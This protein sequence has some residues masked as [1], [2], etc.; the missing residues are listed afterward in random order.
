MRDTSYN[1]LPLQPLLAFWAAEVRLID[2]ST[3]V[4]I[5]ETLNAYG[6]SLI[7]SGNLAQL[8]MLIGPILAQTPE[9]QAIFKRIF[10]EQYLPLVT[11]HVEGWEAR[12]TTSQPVSSVEERATNQIKKLR[13]LVY[14]LLILGA[15]GLNVG[16]FKN[17]MP[18][19][20][21]VEEP[22]VEGLRDAPEVER[23]ALEVIETE[24]KLPYELQQR[25]LPDFHMADHAPTFSVRAEKSYEG[26]DTRKPLIFT[27]NPSSQS[28]AYTYRWSMDGEILGEEKIARYQFFLP[29]LYTVDLDRVGKEGINGNTTSHSKGRGIIFVPKVNHDKQEY[30]TFHTEVNEGLQDEMKV[31]VLFL[32]LLIVFFAEGG[33]RLFKRRAK[34]LAFKME[35]EKLGDVA[36]ALPFEH[37]EKIFTSDEDLEKLARQLHRR[38]T[39]NSKQL[40]IPRSIDETIKMAG[41]PHLV[42][43]TRTRQAEYVFLLDDDPQFDFAQRSMYGLIEYLQDQDLALQQYFFERDPSVAFHPTQIEGLDW[44]RITM[45]HPHSHLI[46]F[47]DGHQWFDAQT[48]KLNPIV[49]KHFDLWVEKT[50]LTPIPQAHWGKQEQ[51][52]SLYFTLLPLERVHEL[53]EYQGEVSTEVTSGNVAE[54]IPQTQSEIEARLGKDLTQWLAASMI[55]PQPNWEILLKVGRTIEREMQ[56]QTVGLEESSYFALELDKEELVTWKNLQLLSQ[57]PW[58]K[59]G[60]AFPEG[61]RREMLGHLDEDLAHQVR[62]AILDVV[63]AA[64]VEEGSLAH[65]EQRRQRAIHE[66]M[67]Y[68]EDKE[69]QEKLRYLMMKDQMDTFNW[70]SEQTSIDVMTRLGRYIQHPA[71]RALSMLA[72]I[73]ILGILGGGVIGRYQAHQREHMVQRHFVDFTGQSLPKETMLTHSPMNLDEW[74]PKE[75]IAHIPVMI[76]RGDYAEAVSLLKQWNE[77]GIYDT[78]TGDANIL[79]QDLKEMLRFYEALALLG[80]ADQEVVKSQL[81]ELVEESPSYYVR[82][83]A[84]VLLWDMSRGHFQAPIDPGNYLDF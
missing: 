56:E 46:I 63:E 35:F 66:A 37:K 72:G 62:E 79:S 8:R 70:E 49:F 26:V 17:N 54:A 58:L 47:S 65:Y 31:R 4:R 39:A 34:M 5:Q 60:E 40:H 36:Q 67:L 29:N 50:L 27:P 42:F 16:L 59:T 30:D 32:F 73:L 78:L 19:V 9:E 25:M 20:V 44:E 38:K 28:Q 74:T 7:Q 76:E 14:A 13:P 18:D 12:E 41:M 55:H 23:K 81:K 61:L 53:G 51:A 33:L 11:D 83:R 68:P 10:E 80:F 2:P 75:R 22:K 64:P 43:D 21:R 71:M 52:L 48:G 77:D 15:V 45:T 24:I 6:P 3:Q 57:I 82:E 69:K 84:F 1:A